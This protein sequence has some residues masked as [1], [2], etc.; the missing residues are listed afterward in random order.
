MW[1]DMNLPNCTG[2]GG[3]QANGGR[4]YTV[5][6]KNTAPDVPVSKVSRGSGAKI[7]HLGC[8]PGGG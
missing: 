6:Q 4:G 1:A 5:E 7:D 3:A 2:L 8:Q